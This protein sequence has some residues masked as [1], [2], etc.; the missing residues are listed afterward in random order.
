MQVMA[1]CMTAIVGSARLRPDRRDVQKKDR[2]QAVVVGE[3]HT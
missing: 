1:A 3:V 2:V